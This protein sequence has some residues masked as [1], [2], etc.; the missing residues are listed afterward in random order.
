M[1]NQELSLVKGDAILI[2]YKSTFKFYL[3]Q[4]LMNRTS[5]KMNV[6]L[7]F[8]LQGQTVIV[9]IDSGILKIPQDIEMEI[10]PL[11]TAFRHYLT[12]CLKVRA[13]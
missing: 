7:Q 9:D 3:H 4:F 5:R 6:L 12:H 13:G 2:D 10:P 1:F 8:R 11:P